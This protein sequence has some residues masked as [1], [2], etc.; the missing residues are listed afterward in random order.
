L[1]YSSKK[2]FTHIALTLFLS[3]FVTAGANASCASNDTAYDSAAIEGEWVVSYLVQPTQ[4]N[5]RG[6]AGTTAKIS[7]VPNS[8]KAVTQCGFSRIC[9]D[10]FWDSLFGTGHGCDE[11]CTRKEF[12]VSAFYRIDISEAK[13]GDSHGKGSIRGDGWVTFKMNGYKLWVMPKSASEIWFVKER[14][15]SD[16]SSTG[17]FTYEDGER[18]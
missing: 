4:Q 13:T 3:I 16:G 5:P 7:F 2:Q 14:L 11:V 6:D 18:L 12:C 10:S 15:N 8:V 1:K 17:D 9:Y